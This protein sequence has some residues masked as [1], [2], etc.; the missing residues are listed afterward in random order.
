MHKII[1]ASSFLAVSIALP[2]HALSYNWS[3]IT[4]AT[5][6]GGGGQLVSGSID[7]LVE[8]NNPGPGITAIVTNT[9]T[10]QL[11]GNY[12]FLNAF[13]GTAFT[14]TGGNLTV[15][16][17][18]LFVSGSEPLRLFLT[19]VGSEIRNL[20]MNPRFRAGGQTSF[21]PSTPVP[22]EFNPALGLGVLG[23]VYAAKKLSRKFLI[24]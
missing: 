9:P 16:N 10:G 12:N 3:F 4:D 20:V 23:F 21:T 17:G 2:V 15:F 11:L 22:F 19:P 8:G 18:A 14:V 1:L 7:G 6:N 24:K 13:G 5:S